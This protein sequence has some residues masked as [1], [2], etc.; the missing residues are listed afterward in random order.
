[1]IARDA[2]AEQAL[3]ELSRAQRETPDKNPKLLALALMLAGFTSAAQST[4]KSK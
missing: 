3:I 2:L 1:M 4:E